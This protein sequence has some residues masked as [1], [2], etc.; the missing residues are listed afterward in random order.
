MGSKVCI[1]NH[2]K[3][4]GN[5]IVCWGYVGIMEN[6]METAIFLHEPPSGVGTGARSPQVAPNISGL[7][8]QNHAAEYKM[9]LK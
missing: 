3:Y 4:K 2:G 5:Y 8:P 6:K 7:G 1:R 9:T